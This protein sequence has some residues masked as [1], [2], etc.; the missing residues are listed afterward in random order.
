MLH[1]LMLA[2]YLTFS[3]IFL[4]MLHIILNELNFKLGFLNIVSQRQERQPPPGKI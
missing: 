1:A 2:Q 3:Q 4:I